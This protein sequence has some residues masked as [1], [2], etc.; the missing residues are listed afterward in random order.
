MAESRIEELCR[1]SQKTFE[2][3]RNWHRLNQDIAENFYP[4]RADFTRSLPMEEFAGNLMESSPLNARETLGNAIDAM[5]RQGDWFRIGTGDE[6]VDTRPG[7]MVSLSQ[8]ARMLRATVYHRHSG[9]A[10]A[11]KETDMDWVSFGAFD[12]SVEPSRD[13]SHLV[14]KPHH[15]RDC[16]WMLDE[17]GLVDT[18]YR[19][20]RMSARDIMRRVERGRWKGTPSAAIQRAAQYEP[21]REFPIRHVLMPTDDMYGSDPADRRR[22][23]HPWVSLYID[24]EGRTML[25]EGGAPVFNYVVGRNRTVS[26]HPYAFS[27]MAL[28]SISDARMIQDMSL[29]LLEQGQ[30]AVDPPTIGAGEVFVRDINMFA[31]GHTEVDLDD[32]R[33][34]D[35]FTTVQTGNIV[36]GLEMKQDT[37]ELMAE[38]WLLNKLTLPSVREMRELEVQVRTDEFRRAALPFFQPIESRYH[39]PL[40]GT[41][42]DMAIALDM[43]PAD[44]FTRELGDR[45][46]NFVFNSPLN[47]AEGTEVVR[48]YY[49]AVNVVATGSQ[50]DETVKNIFDARRATEDALARGTR[51]EWLIPEDQREQADEQASAQADLAKGAAIAREAAGVT[52]DVANAQVAAQQAGLV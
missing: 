33:L 15:L 37:R 30:K 14:Y 20:M 5:L 29:V 13:M 43:I 23:R 1:I 35:V 7:N 27:P 9:I 25:S 8:A 34:Q 18:H 17:D 51:P 36:I 45:E 16:A 44:V 19:N 2:T 47:E 11:F 28:N 10:G 50:I 22:I 48:Q 40:L 52:A 31:G 21:G 42:F 12:M 46:V 41:S 38:A 49:E 6:T 26:G 4:L 24:M 39:E 3:F 32:R